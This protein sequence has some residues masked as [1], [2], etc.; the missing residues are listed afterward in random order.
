MPEGLATRAS[1][2]GGRGAL[3]T[4][5]LP[6]PNQRLRVSRRRLADRPARRSKKNNDTYSRRTGCFASRESL[7]RYRR[8]NDVSVVILA[9]AWTGVYIQDRAC[10]LPLAQRSRLGQIRAAQAKQSGFQPT[11]A[12][13]RHAIETPFRV[14]LPGRAPA[15]C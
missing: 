5:E 9:E 12:I 8:L 1:G 11:L 7:L 15:N 4:G 10:P 3:E 14:P 6:G 2:P 13:R